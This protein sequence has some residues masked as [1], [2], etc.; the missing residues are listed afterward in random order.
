MVILFAILYAV[1]L[2]LLHKRIPGVMMMRVWF[3][4]VLLISVS[5]C[6]IACRVIVLLSRQFKLFDRDTSE[7][8]CRVFKSL[9]FRYFFR[10]NIPHIHTIMMEGS[11][12][13]DCLTPGTAVCMC[14]TSFFDSLVF[15]CFCPTNF[16]R[17]GK[18][19]LKS[20]LQK[21]PIFGHVVKCCGHF[22]VYFAD[23]KSDSFSVQ[24]DKQAKVAEEVDQFLAKGGNLCFFP[25]GAL[26]KTPEVL[27]DFRLGSFN[28]I[29]KHNFPLRYIVIYGNAEVWHPKLAGVPGYPADLYVFVGEF[30]YDANT[31]AR[32]L[33]TNF[34]AEMQKKMDAIL[35]RRKKDGYKP[36]YQPPVK[37]E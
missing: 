30:K 6:N 1:W 34:R 25:E 5:L 9:V 20:S 2:Y 14:H 12:D 35:E 33:A 19:F 21:L 27:N 26:N 36:W 16:L 24:K 10:V 22:P 3:T 7:S 31:D 32:T 15:L 13:F 17:N 4:L 8:Y 18:T 11:L 29:V 37:T 28:T 23:E